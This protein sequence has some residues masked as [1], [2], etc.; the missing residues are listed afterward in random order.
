MRMIEHE[1]NTGLKPC[2][3]CGGRAEMTPW[4]GAPFLAGCVNDCCPATPAV[5]G[6]NEEDTARLWNRRAPGGRTEL[7]EVLRGLKLRG[8]ITDADVERLEREGVE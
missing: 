7:A 3:F 5:T 2:P 1:N 4:H 8:V 6:Y